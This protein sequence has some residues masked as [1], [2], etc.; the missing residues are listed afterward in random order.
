MRRGGRHVCVTDS[1]RLAN[2]VGRRVGAHQHRIFHGVD[3]G[4]GRSCALHTGAATGDPPTSCSTPDITTARSP[5]AQP[6]VVLSGP[7]GDG[8]ERGRCSRRSKV[9]ERHSPERRSSPRRGLH[10]RSVVVARFKLL[11]VLEAIL[12][13]WRGLEPLGLD[14]RSIY[15][16]GTEGTRVN[17]PQCRPYLRQE[18]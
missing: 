5:G 4:A 1:G 14:W 12:N 7:G 13:P 11:L 9:R 6:H 15:R 18:V 17:A 10:C 8:D 16:A 2:A 3:R